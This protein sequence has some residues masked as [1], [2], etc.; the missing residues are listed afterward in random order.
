[1]VGLDSCKL[2]CEGCPVQDDEEEECEDANSNPKCPYIVQ[3]KK[4]EEDIAIIK[5]ALV[6]ADLQGGLVKR[7]LDME[8]RLQKRWTPKD[9]GTLF[10]GVAALITALVAYWN[11]FG[12]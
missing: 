1:V 12:H 8:N 2:D 7:V 5:T 6:G 3:M 11:S 9:W 4:Q 10:M